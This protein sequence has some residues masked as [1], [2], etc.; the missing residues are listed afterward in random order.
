MSRCQF[1][2][3]P[4]TWTT[5]LLPAGEGGISKARDFS[6]EKRHYRKTKEV[7]WSVRTYTKKK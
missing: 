1:Y 3:S 6:L 2:Y 5:G 4:A 7:R